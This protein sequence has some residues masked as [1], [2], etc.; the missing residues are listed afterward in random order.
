MNTRIGH[1]ALPAAAGFRSANLRWVAA[2]AV[3]VVVLMFYVGGKV[4]IMRVGYRIEELEQQKR[5]LERTN[6]AL[7]IE[8]SSLSSPGRIEEI[9]LRQFGMVR[10]PKDGI[11]VVKRRAAAQADGA[12]DAGG[13]P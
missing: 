12:A 7:K 4:Q 3:A 6:R 2:A 11:V 13:A 1:I 9:A 8:A 10:P 5:E